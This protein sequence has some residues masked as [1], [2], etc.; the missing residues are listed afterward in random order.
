MKR[1][2]N[3]MTFEFASQESTNNNNN[4]IKQRFVSVYLNYPVG[5][6]YKYTDGAAITAGEKLTAGTL[7]VS[8]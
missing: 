6:I 1:D 2:L 5:N 4:Y 3:L 8:Y 7:N